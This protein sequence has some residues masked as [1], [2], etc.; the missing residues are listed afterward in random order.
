MLIKRKV[1]TP[2]RV[3]TESFELP[4]NGAFITR[5]DDDDVYL[6]VT[7]DGKAYYKRFKTNIFHEI[8]PD[9]DNILKEWDG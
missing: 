9:G 1:R 5:F 6:F 8:I 7:V 4:D 2:A 3:K